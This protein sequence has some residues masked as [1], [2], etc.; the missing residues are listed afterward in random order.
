VI[1]AV[2]QLDEQPVSD[3]ADLLAGVRPAA[4]FAATHRGI[5]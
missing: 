1:E 2:R 3:L 5:Q 4:A